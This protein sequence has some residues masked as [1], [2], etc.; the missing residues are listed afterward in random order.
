MGAAE[1]LCP[2]YIEAVQRSC[3]RW[4][5]HSL[6]IVGSGIVY[7]FRK[8]L[9]RI[10]T[11]LTVLSRRLTAAFARPAKIPRRSAPPLRYHEGVPVRACLGLLA[12][13]AVCW[14]NGTPPRLA[15]G[16]RSAARNRRFFPAGG[17]SRRSANSAPPGPGPFGL[18]VSVS[19]RT[20]VTSNSGPGPNSL[21][22][23]E[24]DK[25]GHW[26]NRQIVAR[27]RDTSKDSES[28]EWRGVFMGLA[29]YGE[30]AVFASEGN[31]GRVSL[32][33]WNTERRRSI[34]LNR[35][36]FDDSYTG[37]LA[38]DFQRGILYAVD[39]ANFRVAVI[40]A[41]TRQVLASV[42]VGRLP[43]ALALSPD[44]RKLYVTNL[45]MFQYQ[46]IPG[47][48]SQR[49]AIPAC[50]SRP[51]D[52]PAA[53]AA[54]GVERQTARG[55]VQV[56]GLGDPNVRGSQ[57][58]GRGG[59]SD[60]AAPKVE[61][62][63]ADGHPIRGGEPRGKQPLGRPGHGRSRVRFQFG[64]RFDHRHRRAH[65]PV[66][67]EI[68]IRIPG[69]ETPARRAAHRH[70]V[71]RSVRLAAGGGGRHQRRWRDR[72]AQPTR[73][74]ALAGG[75]VSGARGPRRRYRVGGQCPR[76]RRGAERRGRP[77]APCRGRGLS[78]LFRCPSPATW[79]A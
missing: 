72:C 18:A 34:D 21:T 44:R 40:D 9:A 53:E 38:L 51:S 19:G 6:S 17:S 58:P 56:P 26:S 3:E 77:F 50:R 36:G 13:S 78:R 35:N 24:R 14:P 76:A 68:P 5:S 70:G 28:A 16:Q 59:C 20:V 31:S 27:A 23:L 1:T 29:F 66:E 25:D 15:S 71:P 42:R 45:G 74:R 32:F 12:L 22:I 11:T 73:D 43:F 65:Q 75:V 64:Q 60:P 46:A 4:L 79:T 49:A 62:M 69:L 63:R 47:A 2:Q 41:R 8:R 57:F 37:D 55:P 52:F 54:A 39:Q 33:D 10:V 61:A 67:A 7:R 48:D 30:H